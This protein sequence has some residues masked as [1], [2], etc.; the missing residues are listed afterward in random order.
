MITV[1][2]PDLR[3]TAPGVETLFEGMQGPNLNPF[4]FWNSIDRI[5]STMA[6]NLMA[7][8]KAEEVGMFELSSIMY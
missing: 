5:K 4:K 8:L 6:A 3:Y 1:D 7:Y 2:A